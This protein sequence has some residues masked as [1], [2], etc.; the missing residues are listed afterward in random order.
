[1]RIYFW[2]KNEVWYKNEWNRQNREGV[3][4][5]DNYEAENYDYDEECYDTENYDQEEYDEDEYKEPTPSWKD[6]VLFGIVNIVCVLLATMTSIVFL[7]SF[8]VILLMFGVMFSA[9]C[10]VDDWK[11]GFKTSAFLCVIG[12]LLNVAAALIYVF[13]ILAVT[14]GKFI[15]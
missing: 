3:K 9:K 6:T 8:L 1:M 13:T 7:S 4:M 10:I 2:R 5:R 14:I 12:T 11:E 15:H